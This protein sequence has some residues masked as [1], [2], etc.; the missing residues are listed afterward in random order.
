LLEKIRKEVPQERLFN[1]LPAG[2]KSGTLKDYFLN[3]P[4]YIF[5]KNRYVK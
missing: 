1:M 4:A 5:A 3:E 2:G